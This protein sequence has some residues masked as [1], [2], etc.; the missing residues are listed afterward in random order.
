M[1]SSAAL[2]GLGL[3]SGLG[4]GLGL[5]VSSSFTVSIL[6][7]S[8]TIPVMTSRWSQISLDSFVSDKLLQKVENDRARG[9]VSADHF[10][11]RLIE[12]SPS[13]G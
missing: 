1:L 5:H 2:L 7:I 11:E 4:L 9:R 10:P 12:R 8:L 3:G 13:F 6:Y